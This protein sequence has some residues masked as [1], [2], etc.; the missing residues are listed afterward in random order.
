[1]N[2]DSERRKCMDLPAKVDTRAFVMSVPG[3]MLRKLGI[4]TNF[5]QDFRTAD[6]GIRSVDVAYTCY[7]W[8]E[9]NRMD[10]PM[11]EA[12]RRFEEG[13]EILTRTWTDI[14]PFDHHG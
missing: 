9:F 3:S 1:M 14:E 7:Q 2:V 6:G 8:G 13:M 10:V 4:I 12:T 5:T 11:N